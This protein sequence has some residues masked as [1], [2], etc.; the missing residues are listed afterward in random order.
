MNKEDKEE[1]RR[2]VLTG[3]YEGSYNKFGHTRANRYDN[4][5][6]NLIISQLFSKRRKK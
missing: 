3:T 2:V 5:K 6:I 4:K 1:K